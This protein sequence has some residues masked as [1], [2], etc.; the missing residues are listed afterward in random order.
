MLRTGACA[1]AC[2][3]YS[4]WFCAFA[5]SGSEVDKCVVA[6][7]H[8]RAR[9]PAWMLC[10]LLCVRACASVLCAS[11]CVP[12]LGDCSCK[13]KIGKCAVTCDRKCVRA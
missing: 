2:M 8:A 11:D 4:L 1:F 5:T 9:V 12:A 7:V 6:C 13:C 10:A 3:K